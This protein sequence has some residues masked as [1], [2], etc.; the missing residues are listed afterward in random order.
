MSDN[1]PK[2]VVAS[3]P[4]SGQITRWRTSIREFWALISA[5]TS[6]IWNSI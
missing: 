1:R 4:I 6:V 5:L 2:T 3:R